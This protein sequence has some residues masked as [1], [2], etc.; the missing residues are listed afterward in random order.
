MPEAR[1]AE[2]VSDPTLVGVHLG[3]VDV[4]VPDLQ[5]DAHDLRRVGRWNLEDPEAELRNRVTVVELD[6]RNGAGVR[7]GG[8]P[9]LCVLSRR[10]A[11]KRTET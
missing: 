2:R 7:D 1:G 6:R 4:P 11:Y 9:A 8:A 3:G 10:E 5:G